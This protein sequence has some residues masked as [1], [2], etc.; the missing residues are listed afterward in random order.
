MQ[1]C[2][3]TGII[4]CCQSTA[5]FA[6]KGFASCC[7]IAKRCGFGEC[8]FKT[9]ADNLQCLIEHVALN[10][11]H[12]C[13][14]RLL[15]SLNG[16]NLLTFSLCLC[17]F[18]SLSDHGMLHASRDNYIQNHHKEDKYVSV[19]LSVCLSVSLCLTRDATCLSGL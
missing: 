12:D 18:V 8:I 9:C 19:C 5:L 2:F 16:L 4:M 15:Y 10:W 14:I 13:M 17:L 3:I 1:N 7:A 6:F 11:K